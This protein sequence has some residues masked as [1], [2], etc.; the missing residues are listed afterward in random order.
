MLFRSLYH[1]FATVDGELVNIVKAKGFSLRNNLARFNK[2]I[3][4]Q[5]VEIEKM[6]S[7]RENLKMNRTM[8]LEIVTSK[9]FRGKATPKRFFYPDGTSRPWYLSELESGI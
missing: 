2:V 9:R 7:I 8:P 1:L 4:G 6:M 5:S 3:S